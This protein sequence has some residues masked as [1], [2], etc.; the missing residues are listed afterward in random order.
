MSAVGR[1]RPVEVTAE[2]AGLDEH[3]RSCYLAEYAHLLHDVDPDSVVPAFVSL[4]KARRV[5]PD[6][7]RSLLDGHMDPVVWDDDFPC[8]ES[9]F[10]P[11]RPVEDVQTGGLL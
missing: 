8:C 11:A 9:E 4:V 1:P 10:P 3:W 2:T 7:T 6:L 5:D